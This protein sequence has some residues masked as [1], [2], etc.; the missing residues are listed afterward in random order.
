MID[1]FKQVVRDYEKSRPRSLQTA[2]GPSEAGTPCDRRLGYRMLGVSPCNNSSDPWAPIVGTAVHSWLEQAFT[3]AGPRWE[4]EQRVTLP[5]YFSGTCDLYDRDEGDVWDHKVLGV[6]TLKA[7]KKDGPS[8]VYRA[9]VQFYGCGMALAGNPVNNVGIIAW[10]RSGQLKDAITWSEPYNEPLVEAL[11]GR[12]D[13]IRT[14]VALLG[15]DALA[16]LA[17]T[18]AKCTWCPFY[19]PGVTEIEGAC[20]GHE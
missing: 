7:L 12:Y 10:S 5:G 8:P 2:I 18:D 16:L 15:V 17:T 20:P 1:T 9:Q 13:A 19:M 3:A 14:T 11:L 4:T 6:T